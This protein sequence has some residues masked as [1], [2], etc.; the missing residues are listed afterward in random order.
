MSD[1]TGMRQLWNIRNDDRSQAFFFLNNERLAFS[2]TASMES[3]CL[4]SWGLDSKVSALSAEDWTTLAK[5]LFS[6]AT[7]SFNSRNLVTTVSI[8]S[9]NGVI[10]RVVEER[11]HIGRQRVVVAKLP[12]THLIQECMA[13]GEVYT[14]S[15]RSL[16]ITNGRRGQRDENDKDRNTNTP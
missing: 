10:H 1:S 3:G 6:R 15:F 8:W 2:T 4:D 16:N 14:G 11:F 7:S 5:S 12:N 9:R 13:T